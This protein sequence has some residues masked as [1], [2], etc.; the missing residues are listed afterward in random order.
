MRRQRSSWARIK[1]SFYFL[2]SFNAFYLRIY[3]V[4]WRLHQIS[5]YNLFGSFL[6]CL[7]FNV[8]IVTL[9]WLYLVYHNLFPLSTLYR[10]FFK[11]F[12]HNL[13]TYFRVAF[14]SHLATLYI[15][16]F[17]FFFVNYFFHFFSFFVK[18]LL[19]LHLHLFFLFFPMVLLY[20]FSP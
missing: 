12:L 9:K 18:F 20:Y 16:P 6:Y 15:L 19:K 8:L 4:Y 5:L 7:F 13:I 11:L 17:L 10:D 2:F 3:F 1:L 14:G